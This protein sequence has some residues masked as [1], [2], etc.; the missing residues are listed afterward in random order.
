MLESDKDLLY[1]GGHTDRDNLYIEPTILSDVTFASASM[2]EEIFGPILPVIDY[3]NLED[4]INLIRN[5]PKPLSLY[6]FTEDKKIE[7]TIPNSLSFG[8]GCVN[9]TILIPNSCNIFQIQCL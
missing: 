4:T 9:D 3:E 2:Q 8:G 6:V 5:H 7:K 1:Y